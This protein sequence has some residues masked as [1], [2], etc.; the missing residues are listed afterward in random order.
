MREDARTAALRESLVNWYPFPGGA[1]AA[2]VGEGA[3]A[4]AR[5]LRGHYECV[6]EPENL[7][8]LEGEY[9]CLVAAGLLEKEPARA[10]ETLRRC[11]ALLKED[12]VLL[13]GWRNR[14]ALKYLCGAVDDVSR[15]PFQSL[16]TR[17]EEGPRP[18]ARWEVK[19]LLARAGFA[20]IYLYFPM[21]DVPFVQAVYSEGMLPAGGIRDR[22]FPYDPCGSP[23]VGA[24][25]DL[26]EDVIREGA[27]PF[28]ADYYLAECRLRG[29]PARRAVYAAL[30][31]DRGQ[32]H[33]FATVLYS[34]GTA[35][36][37]ALWPEGEPS[38]DALYANLEAL[39]A[40]GV[41]A[42]EQR[43]VPGAIEMPLRREPTLLR[44]CAEAFRKGPEAVWAELDGLW[45]DVLRSSEPGKISRE[46]AL[47]AWGAEPEALGPILETGYIDMIPF[48]AFRTGEGRLYY[49]Q[50][51]CVPRC[52]AKYVLFRAIEY[53]WQVVDQAE[54]LLP[55][56]EA[57]RRYGLKELWAG[58][59]RRE[60]RFV[61]ANRN[62]EDLG[63]LYSWAWLDREAMARRR[64]LLAGDGVGGADAE[65]LEG[66][67]K[68]QLG[69]LRAFDAYCREK[70]L[71]YLAVRG[72]LL[73]AARHGG[74]IPWDDRCEVAMPRE[75]FDRLAAMAE[76]WTEPLFLQTPRS[77]P[78]C[79]A[80]GA[81]R[82]MDARF[83]ACEPQDK[84]RDCRKGVW[85]DILP[86]DKCPDDERKLARLRRRVLF[87]QRLLWAWHYRPE[88]GLIEGVDGARL[89]G[90]Y[91]LARALGRERLI[92]SLERIC[93][94]TGGPADR[95]AILACRP[96]KSGRLRDVFPEAEC[97][98]TAELPFEDMRVRV[99]EAYDSWLR[100][101]Y[102][103]GYMR[104]PQS[105][106]FR[107]RGVFYD[108]KAPDP[109]RKERD[110]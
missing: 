18:F 97:L 5:A 96:E 95:R 100:A 41:G 93:R 24:E 45:R 101:R 103:E 73:G 80:G 43:R 4:M 1:R 36:K 107:S 106:S 35:R 12:G 71:R 63:Q 66:V 46:E 31:T 19:E 32:E 88:D 98:R 9:D 84:G 62:Y 52:P 60:D 85:I 58:F 38:L 61:A 55:I 104:L 79:F 110:K 77:D 57:K 99:P 6:D 29:A 83:P 86:L 59:R 49:D 87:R 2:A 76:E 13:L 75:D 81:I 78:H 70:G 65:L 33:G 91:L 30:S 10:E 44:Y 72:T 53:T 109:H 56:E 108:L 47:E 82:L 90:Y 42:I 27:L 68:A 21:P 16:A 11:A 54:R 17:P 28:V 74:F 89:S 67:H 48:N 102:G 40:R 37:Q 92:R 8:A 50:E 15:L 22:V 3:A 7:F 23:L 39:R 64:K 26:Y 25:D 94:G 14:F 20:E 105:P 34:D 69:L 51:F